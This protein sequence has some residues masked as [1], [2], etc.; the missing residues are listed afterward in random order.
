[1]LANTRTL[2]FLFV[3]T[4][5][6]VDV[7]QGSNENQYK[8]FA[9]W[10]NLDKCCYWGNTSGKHF[11]SRE[12]VEAYCSDNPSCIGFHVVGPQ[13]RTCYHDSVISGGIG[14]TL[15]KKAHVLI[16]QNET[17]KGRNLLPVQSPNNCKE[18]S[19]LMWPRSEIKFNET[20]NAEF[21]TACY[22]YNEELNPEVKSVFYNQA[23]GHNNG[24]AVSAPIC[25][26][27]RYRP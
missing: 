4:L 3:A 2:L 22:L 10:A 5:F 23:F 17:C 14:C 6:L 18:I 9:Y 16:E 26:W 25:R 27:D 19:R 21:P 13:W 24:Q 12:E 8:A 7:A 15:Y 1:M 20:N 11:Y